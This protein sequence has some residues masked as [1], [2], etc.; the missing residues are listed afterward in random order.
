MNT[1]TEFS[2]ILFAI[3]MASQRQPADIAAI[4]LAAARINNAAP[5]HGEMQKALAWL[6]QKNLVVKQNKKYALSKSGMALL[7]AARDSSN[8]PLAIWQS[9][10]DGILPLL[11]E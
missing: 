10:E 3:G 8:A 7:S 2:W 5:S 6:L 11:G 1:E 4:S 9:L